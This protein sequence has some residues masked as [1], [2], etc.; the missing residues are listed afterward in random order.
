MTQY[1][2]TFY[3]MTHFVNY[4]VSRRVRSVYKLPCYLLTY[5]VCY[6]HGI[7]YQLLNILSS[8]FLSYLTSHLIS[9]RI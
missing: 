7:I 6:S 8:A 4:R 5:I 2:L 1:E 9:I 3:V